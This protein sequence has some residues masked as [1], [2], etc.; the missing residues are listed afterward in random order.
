VTQG[1]GGSGEH[2]RQN[3]TVT[4]EHSC[5]KLTP[6]LKR[7]GGGG[8]GGGVMGGGGGVRF[9]RGGRE[10]KNTKGAGT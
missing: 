8:G 10:K 4:K 9:G 6:T 2:L 3:N 5:N 7:G 1:R